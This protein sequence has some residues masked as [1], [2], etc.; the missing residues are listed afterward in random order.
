LPSQPLKIP[1]SKFSTQDSRSTQN[2]QPPSTATLRLDGAVPALTSTASSEDVKT[3]A[4]SIDSRRSRRRAVIEPI[5]TDF[6]LDDDKEA[7]RSETS[8]SDDDEFMEEI[9]AATVHEAKPI[10][11]SKSPIAPVFPSLTATRREGNTGASTPLVMRAAST[12]IRGPL[13]VPGDAPSPLART[14][15]SGAAFLHKITQQASSANM[16]PKKA[17]L[18]SSISQRIKALEKLSAGTKGS[19]PDGQPRPER[20]SAAFFSVRKPGGREPSR[21]P[22][23]AERAQSLS[24]N[25]TPSPPDSRESSP[26]AAKFGLR[27]RSGSMA[28]RLS[29]F[30]GGS[31]RGQAE[32]VEVTA[33]IIRDP[34]L[35][36]PRVADHRTDASEVP[37]LGL[38]QSPLVVDHR[39]ADVAADPADSAPASVPLLSTGAVVDATPR[40]ETIQERRMSREQRRSQSQDRATADD[41]EDTLGL[42][43]RRRS[44]LS[45]VKD[46]IKDRRGSLLGTR[47]PSTDNLNLVSP[48]GVAT[49]SKSPSRPPS[50]HTTTGL[51][52]RLSISSRRS[53]MSK[54]RDIST[55]PLPTP[56]SPAPLTEASGSSDETKSS[57]GDAGSK[58]GS[59]GKSRATRFM[60]RLSSS[61]GATR[62]S[63][64][65]TISPTVAEEDEIP[66]AMP[67]SRGSLTP[68][69]PTIVSYLGDVNIQF[70]DNLL[71]KRRTLCLD[72]Q[73]FLI[74]SA[75]QGVTATTSAAAAAGKEK[76]VG[77]IKRYHLSDFRP[78]YTPEMEVQE[79]PNSVCLDFVDGSGLQI[80]CEDRAGQLN[81]LHGEFAPTPPASPP[82]PTPLKHYLAKQA[83]LV[84]FA[85]VA[86][87]CSRMPTKAMARLGSDNPSGASLSAAAAGLE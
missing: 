16:A 11:V 33:R 66:S 86:T 56:L 53:S 31:T 72:S 59:I 22:S 81:V 3:D 77:A 40:K 74:L 39:K 2:H 47:S 55:P 17:N 29:V 1:T 49:P 38:K 10:T 5:K 83:A 76:Q 68:Q 32:S 48:A 28:G 20:P 51:A 7:S 71:W 23:V 64:T 15:S 12:P 26:E 70:P 13:L 24:R 44:S 67:S 65:P 61:L 14:V 63:T 42:R 85:D 69:Q 80:A 4:R 25:Q 36:F 82:T 43:P 19:T 8:L 73:G 27:D 50:V 30:E 41:A 35:P 54:D 84:P 46:F 60:R 87:Q 79:L 75:V 57:P 21:S 9:Q 6:D 58:K 34:G 45:I 52:R 62:K 37:P 18:G 78:P